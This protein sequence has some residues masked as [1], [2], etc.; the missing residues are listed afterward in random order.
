[1]KESKR[2]FET[3]ALFDY[4]GVEEHLSAMAAR[5]WRL[6]KIG[7]WFWTYRRAE[8][9]QVRYAVTYSPDGSPFNPRPTQGQETLNDLCTA[10]GWT[11]VTDWSQMA[12]F[13]TEAPDPIP[14]ETDEALRLE[15]I[16]RAMKKSFLPSH[17]VLLALS[18]LMTVPWLGTLFTK[19]LR[20][21]SSGSK[22][23]TGLIYCVL[24]ALVLTI[25]L[26]YRRWLI[27]SKRSVAAGGPCVRAGTLYRRANGIALAAMAVITLAWMLPEL[28]AGN[29]SYA[30]FFLLYMFFF[31]L[32]VAAVRGTK[33]FLRKR[34]VS[35]GK[36]IAA[37]MAV[38]IVLAL[39][40]V[41]GMTWGAI[42]PGWFT[43]GNQDTYLYQN[44]EWDVSPIAMPLTAED[45]LGPGQVEHTRRYSY[46]E[47]SV[48][49]P[50]RHYRE[51][52][53][54]DGQ[55]YFLSYEI[56]EPRTQWLYDALLDD[57]LNNSHPNHLP[58]LTRYYEPEDPAPWGAEAVCQQ[59]LDGSP[60]R[61]WLLCWPG[62]VAVITLDEPPTAEQ[63][64]AI[65]RRLG[66][67]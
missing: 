6:E 34:G 44:Q 65:G 59:Y 27:A 8:P 40:L 52:A 22:L 56:W 67:A 58:G 39:V 36:N 20:I 29:S 9:A 13:C 35:K 48:F 4:Q 1:M 31:F 5:G 21:F 12:I 41:S 60:T 53:L 23:Y 51:T 54:V 57:F 45:L 63:A 7:T 30:S 25:L 38:D 19:P 14:L 61:A 50:D 42:H 47:G 37:T 16:R 49:L 10:A 24:L 43:G 3:L 15:G 28:L 62:R 18:L 46:Q 17:Y 33:N 2:C 66:P 64:A 32:L 55:M 11:K 26:S